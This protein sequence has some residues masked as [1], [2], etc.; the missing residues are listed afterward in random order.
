MI[1]ICHVIRKM[2]RA[3]AETMIMNLFRTI[4]RSKIQF[5]F[6]LHCNQKGDYDEEIEALGGRIFRI[7]MPSALQL[8]K[9]FIR[10][11]TFFSMHPE[12]SIVHGHMGSTA[13]FYLKAA[14]ITGKYTIAHS[15]AQ[16]YPISAEQLAFRLISYPTRF[17]ADYFMGAS[18][19]ALQ[20][21]YG[22]KVSKG[23]RAAILR[24]GINSQAFSF[25][26]TARKKIRT[27]LNVPPDTLL[28]IAVARLTAQKNHDFL[29]KVFASFINK[30]PNCRLILV[31]RGDKEKYLLEKSKELGIAD[32]IVFLGVRAD[33]ADVLSASDVF[34]LTSFS[35]GFGVA[36]LEAQANGLPC[37][38]SSGFPPLVD[39]GE[40]VHFMDTSHGTKLWIDTIEKALNTLPDFSSRFS[41]VER[42]KVCNFDISE[43]T[44]WLEKFYIEKSRYVP[45]PQ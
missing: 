28:F 26:P 41:G 45:R 30:N 29:F 43:T 13:A 37:F 15:H 21:R 6:L 5:D 19:E 14:K 24:N 2:D 1:R 36:A 32:K 31:G 25:S 40:G 16:K 42:V 11:K 22:L 23:K 17:T 12:I 33:V 38:L 7:E 34:I 4:D 35:E 10:C 20:D 8:P 3:G 18:L 9:Y 39:C 44:H 27:E